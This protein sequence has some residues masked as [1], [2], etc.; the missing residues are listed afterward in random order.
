MEMGVESG[1]LDQA[2]AVP[3]RYEGG[4]P[5]APSLASKRGDEETLF[6]PA[7]KLEDSQGNPDWL[8]LPDDHYHC[9]SCGKHK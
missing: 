8:G 5:G 6:F 7:P 1:P 2:T 9:Y 3:S 4:G